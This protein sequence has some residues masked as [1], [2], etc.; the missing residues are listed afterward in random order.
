MSVDDAR[1]IKEGMK[2]VCDD[3]DTPVWY[4]NS[5]VL[6][7]PEMLYRLCTKC[8]DIRMKEEGFYPNKK[9][10]TGTSI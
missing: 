6:N 7:R 3:C 10:K 9:S 1:L 8:Y 4:Y 5:H 2:V